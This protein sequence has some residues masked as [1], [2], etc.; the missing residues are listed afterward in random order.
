M[1]PGLRNRCSSDVG[2]QVGV[3]KVAFGGMG[4]REWAEPH[5]GRNI[6]GYGSADK[7][8]GTGDTVKANSS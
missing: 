1:A 2:T 6:A 3:E 5:Q 7:A 8:C 4:Q